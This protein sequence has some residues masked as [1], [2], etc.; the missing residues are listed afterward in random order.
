[1][2]DDINF[3]NCADGDVLEGSDQLSCG[4]ENDTCSWYADYT[5]S[6]LWKREKNGLGKDGEFFCLFLLCHCLL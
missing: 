3:E 6:I 4:F 5:A 2:L 1:M